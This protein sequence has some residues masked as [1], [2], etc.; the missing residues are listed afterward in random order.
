[1]T[2]KKR[3]PGRPQTVPKDSQR[4]N[5]YLTPEQIETAKRLG[6]SISEGVRRALDAQRTE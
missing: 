3:T 5:V 4:I 2:N 1:M 6:G